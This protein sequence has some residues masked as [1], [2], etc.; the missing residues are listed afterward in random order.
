M[1]VSGQYMEL[2]K[3]EAIGLCHISHIL[4]SLSLERNNPPRDVANNVALSIEIQ[5]LVLAIGTSDF[6]R[7]LFKSS[8]RH[9]EGG[10]AVYLIQFYKGFWDTIPSL[11]CFISL[12]IFPLSS[13]FSWTC[14]SAHRIYPSVACICHFIQEILYLLLFFGVCPVSIVTFAP[15]QILFQR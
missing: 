10:K 11:E 15:S 4:E 8:N 2:S 3:W 12:F 9:W 5:H 13:S 6:P 14:V 7:F 1:D